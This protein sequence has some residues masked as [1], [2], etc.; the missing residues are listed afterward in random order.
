MTMGGYYRL[1]KSRYSVCIQRLAEAQFDPTAQDGRILV[2]NRLSVARILVNHIEHL[3]QANDALLQATH[4]QSRPRID[5]Q[6]DTQQ[7]DASC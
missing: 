1:N 6:I 2:D 3:R 7:I 5:I 4:D